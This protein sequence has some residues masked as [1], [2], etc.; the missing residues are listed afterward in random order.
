MRFDQRQRREHARGSVAPVRQRYAA[1]NERKKRKG[2]DLAG[3]QQEVC[4]RERE[5]ER[6]KIKGDS[7]EA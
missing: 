2:N 4:P 6:G 7:Q 5:P 3:G 1:E